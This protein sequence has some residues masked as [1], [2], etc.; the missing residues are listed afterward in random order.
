MQISSDL[1]LGGNALLNA[2]L[3]NLKD[4][5]RVATTG[6]GALAT[7]YA[8]GQTVD[9][10]VLATG[11]RILLKDQTTGSEN[12]IYVVQ[13][14]GAPLRASDAASSALMG[15]GHMVQSS[16]G[17]ANGGMR[18]LCTTVDPIVLGTTALV[19]KR[20]DGAW[21]KW[22]TIWH[23]AAALAASAA[24]GIWPLRIDGG[25]PLISTAAQNAGT[26]S[27][28]LDPAQYAITGKLIQV[29]ILA[30]VL[31]LGTA[32]GITFTFRLYPIT[33]VAAGVLTLGAGVGDAVIA[34]PGANTQTPAYGAAITMPAVGN[35]VLGCLT[36]GAN[37]AV[38]QQLRA[39]LQMRAI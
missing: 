12:G 25:T 29:R 20:S 16:E 8:A 3:E 24:G 9:G 27:L 31:T 18:W 2:G 30:H 35:Y 23:A 15:S 33:A 36:S 4:T 14:S 1:D 13:A 7:A 6:N 26:A 34:T 11:N 17:T 32:P 22:S 19:Y 5:V 39:A 21:D 10:V 38:I 37:S 28:P